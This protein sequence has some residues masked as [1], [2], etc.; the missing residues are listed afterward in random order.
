MTTAAST[1]I[2]NPSSPN[3]ASMGS[4]VLAKRPFAEIAD[5]DDDDEDA[6]IAGEAERVDGIVS[7]GY[8]GDDNEVDVGDDD[9]EVDDIGDVDV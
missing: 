9:D 5:S 6:D 2:E 3:L 4:G 8:E 1:A 7:V